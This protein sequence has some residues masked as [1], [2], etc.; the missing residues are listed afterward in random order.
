MLY[1]LT[2]FYIVSCQ[3]YDIIVLPFKFVNND[4]NR[5]KVLLK[6]DFKDAFTS[7]ERDCILKEVHATSLP[8]TLS[9]L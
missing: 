2:Q 7:I 1:Q 6:L 3:K 5:G 9:M 4:Q 8:L